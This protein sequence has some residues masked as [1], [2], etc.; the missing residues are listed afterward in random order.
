MES[1]PFFFLAVAEIIEF[2]AVRT[3]SGDF[4]MPFAFICAR[5][6]TCNAAVPAQ[7]VETSSLGRHPELEQPF[8]VTAALSHRVANAGTRWDDTHSATVSASVVDFGTADTCTI[9]SREILVS[10]ASPSKHLVI[11]I[12]GVQSRVTPTTSSY[13]AL[14]KQF[15][16]PASPSGR[17]PPLPI[18]PTAEAKHQTQRRSFGQLINFPTRPPH[19][20]TGWRRPTHILAVAAVPPLTKHYPFE[21]HFL[22]ET[23]GA[24]NH[25]VEL[26]GYFTSS[27]GGHGDAG[28]MFW[29]R[30]ISLRGRAFDN[31]W[32]VAAFQ[33]SGVLP[34]VRQL[35]EYTLTIPIR[36]PPHDMVPAHVG[37]GGRTFKRHTRPVAIYDWKTWPE[38]WDCRSI[39]FLKPARHDT[40]GRNPAYL[41]S[42]AANE[43]YNMRMVWNVSWGNKGTRKMCLFDVLTSEGNFTVPLRFITGDHTVTDP[44]LPG[45]IV[46][47]SLDEQITSLQSPVVDAPPPTPPR[48]DINPNNTDASG[49][50][51]AGATTITVMLVTLL[52]TLIASVVWWWLRRCR[53][54][55]ST[56]R[57]GGGRDQNVTRLLQWEKTADGQPL[58]V[59]GH[60]AQGLV[61]RGTYYGRTSAGES[62]AVKEVQT[63]MLQLR[64]EREILA[65]L[66]HPNIVKYY[67]FLQ[68]GTLTRIVLEL[69]E[70]ESLGKAMARSTMDALLQHSI[71]MQLTQGLAY[72]HSR[73]IVHRDLKPSNVLLKDQT[74][75][76]ADFGV[77]KQLGGLVST[78]HNTLSGAF[79]TTGFQAPEMLLEG[80]SGNEGVDGL[81]GGGGNSVQPPRVDQKRADVFSL[82]VV[83]HIV[84][85]RLHPFG[86]DEH[87]RNANICRGRSAVLVPVDQHSA[88]MMVEALIHQQPG[89]RP[90]DG[91]DVLRRFQ[92]FFNLPHLLDC[93]KTL[94]GLVTF[95]SDFLGRGY[96]KPTSTCPDDVRRHRQSLTEMLEDAMQPHLARTFQAIHCVGADEPAYDW[97]AAVPTPNNGRWN[98]PPA[99]TFARFTNTERMPRRRP[100]P[101]YALVCWSRNFY[102]HVGTSVGR[103]MFDCPAD[104]DAFLKTRFPWLQQTLYE[105]ALQHLPRLT[106]QQSPSDD[107]GIDDDVSGGG[108]AGGGGGGGRDKEMR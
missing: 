84:L 62:V 55:G 97:T 83:M 88:R 18:K 20:R 16:V 25:A 2:V 72:L 54:R 33:Q 66:Q 37:Y 95:A 64:D 46:P 96:C 71:C 56:S 100:L 26:V 42:L 44:M 36:S 94:A 40:Y 41:H 75:K 79:G 4:V 59:L 22:P 48:V 57:G 31:P 74:V 68:E 92:P 12:I 51:F 103:R 70:A 90:C 47:M 3:S 45:R 10:N 63:H 61:F 89:A 81:G 5:A 52:V 69:C 85:T 77:S 87:E 9:K 38:M 76:I 28:A 58:H 8:A 102:S 93:S 23:A 6:D 35:S 105:F 24:V 101:G 98:R 106:F 19:P 99:E 11:G 67:Q 108:G 82:G 1:L 50:L 104:A 21:L 86:Q 39:M 73:Q 27:D 14:G 49:L 32:G 53:N 29:N 34:T 30:T 80:H 60:G 13:H 107:D 78:R 15:Y 91:G 7:I 43:S 17:K 65:R